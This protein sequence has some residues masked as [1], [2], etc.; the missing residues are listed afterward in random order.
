MSQRVRPTTK[1]LRR[2]ATVPRWRWWGWFLVCPCSP[3]A[4]AVAAKTRSPSRPL[5]AFIGRALRR[6]PPAAVAGWVGVGATGLRV[7]GLPGGC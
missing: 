2:V 4:H 7:S 6:R 5:R 1:V 3:F